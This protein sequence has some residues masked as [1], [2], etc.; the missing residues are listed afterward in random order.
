MKKIP[1]IAALSA[2]LLV[3]VILAPLLGA[4]W[5]L[6]SRPTGDPSQCYV[7]KEDG[8]FEPCKGD[9]RFRIPVAMA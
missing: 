3:A 4:T 5:P 2:L 6:S 8:E 7:Q 9:N 1:I